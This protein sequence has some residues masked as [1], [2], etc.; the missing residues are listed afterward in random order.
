MPSPIGHS[1][2]GL[3][4]HLAT[5]R[6][7]QSFC[8]RRMALCV[9]AAN[10]PDLDFIPGL[11]A[12]EPDRFHHGASHSLGF[13]VVFAILISLFLRGMKTDWVR[14]PFLILLGLYSSHLALDYLSID[15][16]PPY[17][18]PLLWPATHKY[19]IAAFPF[20]PDIR[21]D[22]STAFFLTSLFS[23]HNLWSVAVECF[24]L[25]P[26]LA[27]VLALKS[28]FKIRVG[29]SEGSRCASE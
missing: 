10:A 21:R 23:R 27:L 22:N 1:L 7:D 12:G 18:L 14:S 19:Y 15:T 26:P 17:G 3:T 6:Q 28:R 24:L 16:A 2:V 29:G 9:F 20:L 5:S 25:V 13:A 4:V 11:L 8:W